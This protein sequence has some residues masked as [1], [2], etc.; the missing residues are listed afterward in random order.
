MRKSIEEHWV[1][2]NYVVRKLD[3]RNAIKLVFRQAVLN[4]CASFFPELLPWVSWCYAAHPELWH[5]LGQ[6]RSET[7]VQQGDPLGPLRF[8]I[9]LQRLIYSNDANDDCLQCCKCS[10]KVDE[11][12]LAG[13]T[14]AVL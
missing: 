10:V 7:G 3:M 13:S 11:R 9:V 8:S 6:L 1:D 4:E 14:S 2:K 5:Q 12:V